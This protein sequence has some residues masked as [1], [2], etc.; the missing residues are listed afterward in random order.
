MSGLL[1]PRHVHAATR[2]KSRDD[3]AATSIKKTARHRMDSDDFLSLKDVQSQL[4]ELQNYIN[5]R[6]AEEEGYQLPK[7]L[8]WRVMVLMLT[9]PETSAG[10]VIVIDDSKEQRSLASPQGVVLALGHAAY[11]DPARFTVNGRLY[12]WCSVGD[13]ITFMKYDASMFQI[14]NGQRLGYLNDTQPIS[15]ID[16]N[17]GVPQ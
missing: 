7:P 9:I 14:A 5:D 16:K 17:W 4:D 15:V 10:G 1:L 12:D 11:S 13:R 2:A 8:G 6:R 3:A